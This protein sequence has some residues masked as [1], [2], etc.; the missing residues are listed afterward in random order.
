[1]SSYVETIQDDF[2]ETNNRRPTADFINSQRPGYLAGQHL[3][4]AIAAAKE[5]TDAKRI[6]VREIVRAIVVRSRLANERRLA[7]IEAMC[8]C[9]DRKEQLAADHVAHCAPIQAA[10]AQIEQQQMDSILSRQPQDAA[11][12][13]DRKR[14]LIELRGLNLRLEAAIA[15]QDQMLE[16]LETER[17]EAALKCSTGIEPTESDLIKLGNPKLLA[18][19]ELTQFENTTAE[20]RLRILQNPLLQTPPETIAAAESEVARTYQDFQRR[21]PQ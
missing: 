14:K 9:N 19:Q 18:K 8:D 12:E 17:V 16:Q 5:L 10:L 20:N 1:M 6:E 3:R 21:V 4:H 13:E 11:L 7:I 15:E 2:A